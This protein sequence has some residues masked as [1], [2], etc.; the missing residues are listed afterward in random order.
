MNFVQ[1]ASLA[2]AFVLNDEA[3]PATDKVLDSLGQGAKAYVPALWWWEVANV[4]LLAER[5]N[6]VTSAE[7]HRHWVRLKALPIE[8]DLAASDEA[9]T[10]TLSLAKK[11]Q[12]TI[13]D[14]AYLEMAIRRDLPLGSL[15]LKLRSA[16]KS[17]QVPLLPEKF[18]DT[19]CA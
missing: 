4:L 2:L 9:W 17:D 19:V 7:A 12:L 13:Y 1:D 10:A 3:T 16:A 14:A 18:R 6:R 11:H 8:V 5:R 15:D